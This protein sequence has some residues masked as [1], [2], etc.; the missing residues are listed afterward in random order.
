MADVVIFGTGDHAEQA[1]YY[2]TTDSPHH[3]AG[4]SVSAAWMKNDSFLGLPL[5]GF[6]EVE[7]RFPPD[8]FSFFLPMSGRRMNCDRQRFYGEAKAKGYELI[9][10][11]S[12]RAILCNNRIGD[13]C[14][15]LEGAN[16]QPFATVGNNTVI[17]C[18]SHIG[19]HTT[20]GGN[21]FISSGVTVCGRCV[22]GDNSYISANAVIDAN[23]TLA[24]GTLAGNASVIGRDTEPWCIYTGQPA[25]KRKIS[26]R[27]YEF[28]K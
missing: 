15:I 1:H 4:F 5:V 12:S 9:S 14:F 8:R 25:S 18:S 19:H 28:L 23:V 3:V 21:I 2:L 26:S 20:V 22:I 16:I 6:E 11:V 7:S 24:E 10:Y 27:T 17:W 13:N